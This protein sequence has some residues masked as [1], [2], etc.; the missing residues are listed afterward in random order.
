V[1]GLAACDEPVGEP[2]RELSPHLAFGGETAAPT[3]ADLDGATCAD[4]GETHRVCWEE[5][6]PRLVERGVPSTE[7]TPTDG[8]FRCS[9]QGDA[10]RCTLLR[11][12]PFACEGDVC[13]QRFP[14]TPND[15]PTECADVE[16]VVIC[17]TRSAAAGVVSG[18]AALGWICG[19]GEPEIC[20]DL[21]PDTPDGFFADCHFEHDP[22]MRRVCR[23]TGRSGGRLGEPVRSTDP[24]CAAGLVPTSDRH[25]VPERAPR[26][27]CWT[28][29]DCPDG[30]SCVLSTCVEGG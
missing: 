8:F 10:R 19:E 3:P 28:D 18:P 26:G 16:G 4:V 2:E 14:R 17:R 15:G 6:G 5:G 27:E 13:S 24:P 22:T 20:V 23:T 9:G 29:P 7:M 1:L 12:R 30:L 25:C 11:R 21:A